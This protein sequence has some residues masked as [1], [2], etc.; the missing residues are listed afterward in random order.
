MRANWNV[1]CCAILLVV[2][3]RT[4]ALSQQYSWMPAPGPYGVNVQ[5]MIVSTQRSVP[6]CKRRLALDSGGISRHQ[7]FVAS[8]GHLQSAD[9]K[10]LRWIL[11]IKR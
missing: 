9:R 2:V 4:I 11:Q 8:H 7:R 6:V 10:D 1:G 5:T 3:S